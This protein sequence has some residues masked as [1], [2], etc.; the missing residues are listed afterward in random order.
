ME[1][2]EARGG[3]EGGWAPG[4]RGRDEEERETET[5]SGTSLLMLPFHTP[6]FFYYYFF[7]LTVFGRSI[8]KFGHSI[9]ST[10]VPYLRPLSFVS[11]S[12]DLQPDDL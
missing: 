11:L 2:E 7:I 1:E 3:G 8:S 4:V 10:T 5:P 9:P 6:T 12:N